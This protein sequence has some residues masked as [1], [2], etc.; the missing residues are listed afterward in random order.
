MSSLT[1]TAIFE[2]IADKWD[3]VE[4]TNGVG[5]FELTYEGEHQETHS[6]PKQSVGTSLSTQF[7]MNLIQGAS[8]TVETCDS[9][10]TD[11]TPPT[12]PF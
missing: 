11:H 12:L 8:E 4:C 6:T 7:T 3:I 5:V 1:N 9:L 10:Y 2:D